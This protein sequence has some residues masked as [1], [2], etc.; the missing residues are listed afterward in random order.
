MTLLFIVCMILMGMSISHDEDELSDDGW[1]IDE[2]IED[3]I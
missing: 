2:Y 3:E 1:Y